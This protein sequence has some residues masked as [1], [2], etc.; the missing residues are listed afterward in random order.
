MQKTTLYL[1]AE[2]HK[3]LKEA[4]KHEQKSQAELIREVLADYMRMK[5]GPVP[6]C[7]GVAEDA[8]VTA[9][10]SEERML[11]SLPVLNA[12]EGAS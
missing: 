2:L 7:I 11:A 6:S 5:P 8:G 4:A 10:E 9:R 1:P 3:L 12:V